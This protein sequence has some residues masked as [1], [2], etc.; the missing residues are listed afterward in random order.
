MVI[1][2][3]N[4]WPSYGNLCI[5]SSIWQLLY[6]SPLMDFSMIMTEAFIELRLSI[7]V[8]DE[9]PQTVVN[10]QSLHYMPS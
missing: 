3:Y 1:V 6:M 4:N 2:I 9:M 7:D 8:S 10:D 5:A